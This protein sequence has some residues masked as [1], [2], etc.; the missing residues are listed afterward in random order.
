M[1]R[2]ERMTPL[3]LQLSALDAKRRFYSR[4]AIAGPAVRGVLRHLPEL[5]GILARHAGGL[6]STLGREA[7]RPRNGDAA[8]PDGGISDAAA[9]SAPVLS[10]ALTTAMSSLTRDELARLEEALGVAAL[11]LYGRRRVAEFS[12][13][14][15]SH[16]HMARLAAL[17]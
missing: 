12:G 9:S 11:R 6:V 2:P 5:L 15:H 8:R 17:S 13:Q 16:S 4:S 14:G 3:E 7:L 10:R 1:L